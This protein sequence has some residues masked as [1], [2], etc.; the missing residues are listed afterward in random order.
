MQP[1][2]R[3]RR[4]CGAAGLTPAPRRRRLAGSGAATILLF[5]AVAAI[6]P[7]HAS[8]ATGFG[9][10]SG[11]TGCIV[12]PGGRSAEEGTQEC[13][14]GKGLLG[15]NAVAVSPDGKNVYAVAGTAGS[16]PATSF[17][18]LVVMSR[19]PATGA[20]AEVGCMSSDG[21][22]GRVAASG[23][24]TAMPSLLGADGVA[25][26]P[27]G[28]TVFISAGSS[29]S[30]VAFSR[31]PENGS[32]TRLGCYQFRPP[33]G[34]PCPPANVYFDA[35][36]IVASADGISLFVASPMQG[37][38]SAFT[39]P[40]AVS[41]SSSAAGSGLATLFAG[42]ES[43]GGVLNPCIAVNGFDGS[44]A[45]GIATGG[46][47][48]LQLS[49]DGKQLYGVAGE[50]D[51]IDGFTIGAGG[52]L[53][54][55]S[56]LMPS[57]PHGLCT[58]SHFMTDPTSLSIAPDGANAYVADSGGSEGKIDVLRRDPT[59]GA[60]S[61]TGCVDLLP[62]EKPKK[63]AH[64]AE[65]EEE[66]VEEEPSG[67]DPCSSVAGL[68]S[69][70]V[71]AVTGD[72]ATVYAL[73][74][75]SAVVFSRDRSTGKL[76]EVSC[77]ADEDTRCTNF[78]EVPVSDAVL[79]PDGREVYVAGGNA[80]TAFGV[81]STIATASAAVTRSGRLRL[82]LDCPSRLRR[83]CAGRLVLVRTTSSRARRHGHRRR[84]A[85][86]VLGRSAHYSILP[87]HR[88]GVTAHL[89]RAGRSLLGRRRH[90][91]LTT[92]VHADPRGGGSGYGRRLELTLA[93]RLA[94][95]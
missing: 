40:P 80:V 78:R 30:V 19:D 70:Q 74:S 38:I 43:G 84:V 10:L 45:V 50:P 69:A 35:A 86:T 5:W 93:R 7:S 47:D 92:V 28:S 63:G 46:I 42:A 21:T 95:R 75:D 39:A 87:G 66:E 20:I 3:R 90:L 11:S 44:C 41:P 55:T 49:P 14:I 72:G 94:R 89:S 64:E 77:A 18:A 13:A 91:R 36:S 71:L 27:D 9:P 12:G 52:T 73:G 16:I 15:V 88:E 31:N 53:G 32:L 76:T 83:P 68:H 51:A 24:C 4:S 82:R 67:P 23:A 2:I 56:C 25:V 57:P 48:G 85:R 65:E 81:G 6:Y 8:A 33:L 22:D 58:A 29:G 26:S 54:E 34:S 62:E 61:D 17:G 37:A 1:P 59:S 60:L 79:S